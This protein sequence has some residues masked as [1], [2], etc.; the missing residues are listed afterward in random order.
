VLT[1]AGV[2]GLML[3]PL[4]VRGR[5]LGV[6]SFVAAESR[7][8]YGP[9]DRSLGE[10][11]ARRCALAIENTRL[12]R[13][14]Q[15]AIRLRDD[16]F[17]VAS[18][19][20]KTPVA[21]L[22]A[23][24]QFMRKR[25][26]RRG[27]LTTAQITEALG[28]VHWQSDR[29]ARLVAQLLDTSRLDAGKLALDPEMTDL[30]AMVDSAVHAARGNTHGH[31][32]RVTAT[33]PVWAHVDALRL[34][35]VITNLLDNAIK[36]SPEGGAVDIEVAAGPDSTARIS[37]RDRGIGIPPEH[38]PH[39]FDRF[40][41]AH[42]GQHFAGVAGM[43]LGLYISRRIVEMHGGT[44]ELE[45]PEDGGSRVTVMLPRHLASDDDTLGSETADAIA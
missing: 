1:E 23:F 14:A 17:S 42:A 19:E 12:Y 4:L 18:H 38:R 22:M 21:A 5:A 9:R 37:V 27:G 32:L 40:Y 30:T 25:A 7:R 26:E 11:L 43:G 41:Q 31:T 36:Y 35:Q 44:I 3:A 39:I 33:G 16:F 6:L 15:N 13:E 2:T 20:L 29:I 24:T 10:E 28:E 45:A 34:E 8:R